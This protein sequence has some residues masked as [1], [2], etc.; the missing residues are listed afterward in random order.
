LLQG[1]A[2]EVVVPKLLAAREG[3]YG[4]DADLVIDTD[5]R[6]VVEIAEQIRRALDL[7][8]RFRT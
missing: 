6:G 3:L 7:P 5:G 2:P 4:E 8:M 1:A